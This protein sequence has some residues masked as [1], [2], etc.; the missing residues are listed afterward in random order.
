MTAR[1]IYAQI[2]ERNLA[3]NLKGKPLSRPSPRGSRSAPSVGSLWS[4]R[5]PGSSGSSVTTDD[6]AVRRQHPIPL[7]A[8]P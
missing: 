8:S 4:E 3:P 2:R 5:S 1:E 6:L 7:S